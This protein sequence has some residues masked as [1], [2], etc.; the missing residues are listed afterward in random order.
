MKKKKMNGG[1]LINLKLLQCTV[2]MLKVTT[3]L[4]TNAQ[5]RTAL[6]VAKILWMLKAQRKTSVAACAKIMSIAFRKNG[7]DCRSGSS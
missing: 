7:A 2:S 1:A 5:V 6:S 4:E 3:L